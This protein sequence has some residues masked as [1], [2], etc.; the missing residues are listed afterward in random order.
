MILNPVRAPWFFIDALGGC[1]IFVATAENQGN[2]PLVNHANRN[3]I[4]DQRENLQ[5]KGDSVNNML[6]N[7]GNGNYRIIARAYFLP[8]DPREVVGRVI[9][10]ICQYEQNHPGI[11]LLPYNNDI[12]KQYFYF[13][14]QYMIA[15]QPARWRFYLKGMKDGS[16]SHFDVSQQGNLM[17]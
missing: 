14:G 1:D 10:Y 7:F 8:T 13:F 6:A 3:Q 17:K 12:K 4:E 5:D 16:L 15:Q 9:A 2:K 11:R